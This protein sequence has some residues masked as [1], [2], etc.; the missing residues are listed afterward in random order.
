MKKMIWVVASIS[1]VAGV[2]FIGRE[3]TEEQQKKFSKCT[4]C[5]DCKVSR[6]H[7]GGEPIG[8]KSDEASSFN[9]RYENRDWIITFEEKKLRV[10]ACF[11]KTEG[12]KV[13]LKAEASGKIKAFQRS[14]FSDA[15][16]KYL[17]SIE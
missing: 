7:D 17:K 12:D 14:C 8:G 6:L 9:A 13:H 16:I 1:V 4:S 15:D 3:R 10:R 2:V 11:V 5:P